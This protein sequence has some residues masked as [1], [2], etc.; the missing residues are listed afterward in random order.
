MA[1]KAMCLGPRDWWKG[2]LWSVFFCLGFLTP[3]SVRAVIVYL[4]S[5]FALA[6]MAVCCILL[7]LASERLSSRWGLILGLTTGSVPWLVSGVRMDELGRSGVYMGAQFLLL[8]LIFCLPMRMIPSRWIRHIVLPITEIGLAICAVGVMAGAPA[9]GR[10]LVDTYSQYY[11]ELVSAEIALHRPIGVFGTHSVAAFAYY[12]LL[13]LHLRFYEEQESLLHLWCA[14]FWLVMI[15]ALS[16]GTAAAM[17]ILGGVDLVW[18]TIRSH[19][20]FAR[21]VGVAAAVACAGWLLYL[22]P[23]QRNPLVDLITRVIGNEANGL[24]SRYN[25]DTG[26]VAQA[27]VYLRLHPL[28][29]IGLS[30]TSSGP[31][32][33][34][35]I[36]D[37]GPVAYLLRGGAVLLVSLYGG[38]WVFLHGAVRNT[39]VALWLWSVVLVFE[40]GFAVLL[41][42]R[43]VALIL[44]TVVCLGDHYAGDREIILGRAHS[45]CRLGGERS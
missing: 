37:S 41:V 27:I 21:W 13:F 2:F 35:I 7:I 3:A 9:V 30:S 28:A 26:V 36:T 1:D 12:L 10:F 42:L 25:T 15:G 11:P 17:L 20:A 29:P 14:S 31:L 43:A 4:P 40:L 19:R 39:R 34:Q 6:G 5:V 38:L 44:L 33:A 22:A 32:A 8:G 45:V 18:T 24:L 23:L 16:S